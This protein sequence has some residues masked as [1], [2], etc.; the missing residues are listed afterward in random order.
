[1]LQ[2][3]PIPTGAKGG[4]GAVIAMYVADQGVGFGFDLDAPASNT[5]Q[6]QV[7]VAA[8]V[9]SINFFGVQEVVGE[10]AW[11]TVAP[12]SGNI[13]FPVPAGWV[14]DF[15]RRLDAVRAVG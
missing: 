8:L 12:S 15:E 13:A 7:A 5:Q 11:Q 4:L 1:M 3:I 2:T 10:S 14:E 6:A 9:E